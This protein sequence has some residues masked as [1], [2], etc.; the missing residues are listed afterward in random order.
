VKKKPRG[1]RVDA[2]HFYGRHTQD[3]PLFPAP[4]G[5]PD[6]WICRRVA[7]FAPAPIPAGAAFGICAECGA[8]IVF[9]PARV[10]SVPATTPKTCMQCSSIMPLPIGNDSAE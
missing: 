1:P 2:G 7:D 8:P 5:R 10:A 9:N 3:G 4:A 6:V